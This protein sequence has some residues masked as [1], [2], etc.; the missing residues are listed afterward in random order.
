MVL[1]LGLDTL[2]RCG[3]NLGGS[4]LVS[5]HLNRALAPHIRCLY[6]LRMNAISSISLAQSLADAANAKFDAKN[7]AGAARLYEAVIELVPQQAL[8]VRL[9]LAQIYFALKEGVFRAR[10]R[11]HLEIYLAAVETPSTDVV[12]FLIL[13]VY[14]AIGPGGKA[15]E[16]LERYRELFGN[17]EFQALAKKVHNAT[18]Y[19]PEVAEITGARRT[20]SM[21]LEVSDFDDEDG[22][23]KRHLLADNPPI[24]LLTEKR[25]FTFGSC[26]ARNIARVLSARKFEVDSFWVGEEVNTAFSN[27]NLLNLILGDEV[28]HRDYY[29]SVLSNLNPIS[30]RHSLESADVVI[31][32]L[33]LAGAF[34]GADGSYRPH[35]VGNYRALVRDESVAY[36]MSTVEENVQSL[37]EILDTLLKRTNVKRFVVTVSPIPLAA[38]LDR[39]SAIS[40][41]VESKSILRAAAGLFARAHPDTVIYFPSFEFFRFV[42]L[43]R[44]GR[45]FGDDDGSVRHPNASMVDTLIGNFIENYR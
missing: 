24:S 4:D 22:L 35:S 28:P 2:C 41:D 44:H 29:S 20:S 38:S 31:Y 6:C 40:A 16:T 3:P 18:S 34:F 27:A 1:G 11:E 21:P 23:I 9:R 19:A 25:I 43:F 36:R 5:L 32:T 45:G 26:F 33:G 37:N 14:L 12:R 8:N 42:P 7:L 17:D 10:A 30:L 13:N 15:V 39:G